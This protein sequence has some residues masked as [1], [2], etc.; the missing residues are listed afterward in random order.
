M[1]KVVITDT[2]SLIL[3]NKIGRL[4][5]FKAVYDSLTITP[6]IKAEFNE[7]IP[8]WISV[9][10]ARDKKYQEFVETQVDKGEASA[11][12][13][14]KEMDN[15][16]VILDDLKARKLANKLKIRITGVLGVIN[17]AKQIGEVDKL[18]PIIDD[19]LKT[20]FRIA[21]IIIDELLRLNYE[22]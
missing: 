22:R 15:V 10:S 19:L 21:P 20:D 4:D 5:L 1:P 16:L 2:S 7:D 13:L 12:A 18:K 17:R 3:L 6:E 14:A 11:I 9:Q 8:E